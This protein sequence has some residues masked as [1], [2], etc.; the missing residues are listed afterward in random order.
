MR[1]GSASFGASRSDAERRHAQC[2]EHRLA[3]PRRSSRGAPSNAR[4]RSGKSRRWW[5]PRLSVRASAQCGDQRARAGA[6]RRRAR[7]G[8][9]PSRSRPASRHSASRLAGEIGWRRRRRRAGRPVGAARRARARARRAAARA[10]RAPNT[11]H[12]VSEFEASRLAPCR[13]VHE[14]SPTAYSPASVAR[15]VEVGRDP[16][17]HV[18]RGRR[19]RDRARARGRSRRGAARRRRSGTAPGRRRACRGRPSGAPVSAIWRW[20]ARATSSRGASSSTNRSPRGVEQP[21]ALAAD[22]LGHEEPVGAVAADDRG[23]VELH[24]LEVGERRAGGVRQQQA[25]RR[26]RPAGS[27]CA[28]TARRRRRSRARPRRSRSRGRRRAARPTQRPPSTS[29]S[30]DAA[31]LEHVDPPDPRRRPRSAGGRAAARSPRR[32]RARSAAREWPPSSPSARRPFRSA[33]KRTPSRSRSVDRA[34]RLLAQD[35]RRRLAHRAAAGRDRVAQVE[36]GAVVGRQRGRQP[37]LRP[38]ARGL[39]QRRGRDQRDAR[40]LAGG[41]QR[42]VQ[43]GGAGARPP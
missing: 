15:R 4:V 42:R 43:P 29:S 35:A 36:L 20:T 34:G 41:A 9:S 33:S 6:G 7:A 40:A 12:S 16:A 5:A 39:G 25:R 18:V 26:R 27:S 32:R 1:S 38:V 30:I 14:H 21:G 8:P 2:C 3:A 13:P 31:A 17:H 37:A 23:R 19:D 10:A 11:K 24:E 28:T 22:R